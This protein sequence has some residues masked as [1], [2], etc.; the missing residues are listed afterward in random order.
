MFKKLDLIQCGIILVM[1]VF[2]PFKG[3]HPI[4]FTIGGW[5][6]TVGILVGFISVRVINKMER[7]AENR[8]RMSNMCIN[9]SLLNS[10]GVHYTN[11]VSS[12]NFR[13]IASI[14]FL[15]LSLWLYTPKKRWEDVQEDLREYNEKN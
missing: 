9:M 8:L 7:N 2:I 14:L 10:V 11:S 4:L 6:G 3:T 12:Q 13:L 15:L 5:L 1:L